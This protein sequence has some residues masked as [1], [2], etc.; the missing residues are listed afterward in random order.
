VCIALPSASGSAEQDL[1][2]KMRIWSDYREWHLHC[3]AE[4]FNK[5]NR[6]HCGVGS[7]SRVSGW[8]HFWS[9]LLEEEE[10]KGFAEAKDQLL[11]VK[12]AH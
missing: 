5:S 10:T 8:N 4:R 2:Y 6:P 12:A 11:W 9:N 3:S 1:R 7:R